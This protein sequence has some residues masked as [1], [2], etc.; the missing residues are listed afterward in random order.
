MPCTIHRPF[1]V[2][3]SICITTFNRA[4][5]IGATLESILVQTNDACE[6]VVLDAGSTDDTQRVVSEY[7]RRFNRLHYVRQ[8][9]NNGFDRD[10]DRVVGLASG[11]YCWLMTDDDLLKPGAVEAVLEALRGDVS[12]II[13]NAETRDLSMSSVLQGRWL[14]FE[15]NRVYRWEDIDRFFLEVG[16]ILRYIGCFVIKR[17][18][19]LV[20]EKERYYGSLFIYL[21]VIFQKQLDGEI[22]V[23]SEPFISYRQGNSHTFSRKMFE[24]HMVN[25][26][27]IVWSLPLS[28]TAK[29]K[30]CSAEPW[31]SFQ[32]LLLWRGFGFYSLAEYRLFI[33]PRLCSIREGLTPTL[34]ALLPGVL[35]NA[36]FVFYYSLTRR[37]YLGV[38]QPDFMLQLMRESRFHLR[39]WRAFKRET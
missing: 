6:V 27:S 35:V 24:T 8:A 36:L 34:V 39:N 20:R 3:L 9:M 33:R 29:S 4:A 17:A 1:G 14:D 18:I 22:L 28:E 10:C 2:R 7:T 32:L 31:R 5:F 15:S 12:L 11:E 21:G 23:I 19:W 26:P 37:P 25:W 13:V 38:W 16:E 30:M